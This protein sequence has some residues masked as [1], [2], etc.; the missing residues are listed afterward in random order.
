VVDFNHPL[1]GKTLDFDV[2]VKDI[3]AAEAK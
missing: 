1:D 3:N 2:K